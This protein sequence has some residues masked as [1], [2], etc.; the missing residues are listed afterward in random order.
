MLLFGC[1][2]RNYAVKKQ[3]LPTFSFDLMMFNLILVFLFIIKG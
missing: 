1:K 3:I 2:V